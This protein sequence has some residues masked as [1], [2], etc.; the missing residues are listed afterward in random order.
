M[1]REERTAS[2]AWIKEIMRHLNKK[3][4]QVNEFNIALEKVK[5]EVAKRKRWIAPGIDGVQNYWWKKL[6]PAQK[7]LRRAFIKIK[8]NNTNIPTWWPTGRT[9]PLSKIKNL[10]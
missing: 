6:E 2:M 1:E 3:V 8:E 9:V 5:K 10:G 4:N 7:A